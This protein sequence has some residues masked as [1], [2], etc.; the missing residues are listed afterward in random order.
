MQADIDGQP[1]SQLF[2]EGAQLCHTKR[3][4]QAEAQ[5]R[6]VRY[7]DVESLQCLSCQRTSAAVVD[8]GRYHDRN[9]SS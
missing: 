4:V 9:L 7:T 1:L 6:I 2:D 8:G 3:A 5:Q